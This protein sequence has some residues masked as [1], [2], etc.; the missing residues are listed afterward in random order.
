MWNARLK[1][2]SLWM[3][4]GVCVSVSLG[5]W[6]SQLEPSAQHVGAILVDGSTGRPLAEAVAALE[7][8]HD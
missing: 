8:R 6:G 3:S 5:V 4:V 1:R 2:R 7:E